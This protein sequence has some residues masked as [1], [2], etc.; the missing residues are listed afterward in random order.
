MKEVFVQNNL[1]LR[2]FAEIYLR[3]NDRHN[4]LLIIIKDFN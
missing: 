4:I 1:I 3:L 2:C